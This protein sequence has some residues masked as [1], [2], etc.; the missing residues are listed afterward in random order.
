MADI[1]LS[2]FGISV[3]AS[4][5][6][7]AVV[8]FTPFFN[9]RY[10]LKWKYFIWIFLAVWLLV[11][12]YT[13]C[14]QFAMDQFAQMQDAPG[15]QYTGAQAGGGRPSRRVIVK[16][17]AQMAAPVT[18]PSG[19]NRL[20][21]TML[22]LLALVWIVGSLVFLSVHLT[23][24]ACYRRQ[25]DK[26]GNL[27]KDTHILSQIFYLK[28]ELGIRRSIQAV[29]YN[30]AESPMVIG[31]LKPVLVL[32]KEHYSP[33]ELFF[34]LK[35]E[36]VHFKRGDVY[37]KL[38]FVT[39][40]AVH[41]FNP[42][43]WIMQ[44]EASVDMELSCDERV[45]QGASY[46]VRKAYTE[47]LLSMLEKRC[48]KK[49]MLSTQFYGG[50]KIMKKRFKNILVKNGKKNGV[51]ILLAT[52]ILTA[53]T[54][55]LVG[56]SITKADTEKK[57]AQNV[58]VQQKKEKGKTVPV[59]EEPVS[60]T[61]LT[62]TKEGEKEQKK[63]TLV[64]GDGYSMYLPN[65]EWKQS[66]PDTWTSA[67]NGQV[68]LWI[69]QFE[70]RTMDSVDQ[71]LAGDGYTVEESHRWKQ[72]GDLV[73]FA[74]LKE[75][76]QDVW[77][78]FYCLPVDAQ[79]GWGSELPVIANTFA[80]PVGAGHA[81]NNRPD[82]GDV[83][84]S[85]GDCQ[86]IRTIVDEFATAY[87]AGNIDAIQTFLAST[88]EGGIDTYESTGTVSSWTV[89]G[90]SEADEKIIKDGSFVASLEFRDSSYE[91]MFWY[92]TIILAKQEG[93]WKIQSYGV[94]G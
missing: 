56:Y 59:P 1:F 81:K 29:T 43:I 87:F 33:E 9:K 49:S 5:I 42:L 82:A 64:A 8:S 53:S 66:G 94:E 86:E 84:L 78:I 46:A 20:G 54:G 79:E 13:A 74:V 90:L 57:L 55:T 65:G 44:K 75:F 28:R 6:V 30:E 14:G 2:I 72:V 69:T 61:I 18:V 22:D 10:A 52:V 16:I 7:L 34:V 39:A 85:T 48:G 68:R 24:Y 23:S 91:D 11:P 37:L 62:F 45:M 27:I 35:H 47:T 70:G 60:E 92:L 32:P 3:P 73:Y 36:L 26:K 25:V 63:A 21:I 38:L 19:Q 89:K 50:V 76:E 40:N 17:P 41:W 88:Y 51:A 4:L 93:T 83:S 12:F 80:L 58:A 15:G 71:E 77:G 67:V 31:F